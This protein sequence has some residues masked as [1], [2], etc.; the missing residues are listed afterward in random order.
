MNARAG[1]LPPPKARAALPTKLDRASG[2]PLAARLRDN[3]LE[4]KLRMAEP[5]DERLLGVRGF[6]DWVGP[7]EQ[8]ISSSL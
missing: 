6:F 3:E 2:A 1:R 8:A 7:R 5:L 4:G